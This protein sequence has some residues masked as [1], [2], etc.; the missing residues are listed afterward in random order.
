MKKAY[1]L[2]LF[3]CAPAFITAEDV[4][5]RTI[6]GTIKHTGHQNVRSTEICATDGAKSFQIPVNTVNTAPDV[7]QSVLTPAYGGKR[8]RLYKIALV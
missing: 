1:S 3:S 6:L 5:M 7:H 8:M 2:G 4:Y